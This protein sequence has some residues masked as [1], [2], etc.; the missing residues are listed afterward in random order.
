MGVDESFHESLVGGGG[1]LYEVT[2]EK[3]EY[4]W[5]GLTLQERVDLTHPRGHECITKERSN[6]TLSPSFSSEDRRGGLC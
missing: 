3:S 6:Q 1:V 5:T 2:H 4:V